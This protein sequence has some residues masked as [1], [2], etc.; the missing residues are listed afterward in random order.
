MVSCDFDASGYRLPTEAEWEY[1]ARAG[2]NYRY[3]GADDIIHV[4]WE[5]EFSQGRSRAV[6]QKKPNDF[7]LYD[8]SGNVWEWCWDRFEIQYTADVDPT[9]GEIGD[10]RVLRGGSW[11]DTKEKAQVGY[12]HKVRSSDRFY[13]QGFRLARTI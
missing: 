4:G 3:A 8:I 2:T 7:G 6:G 10:Y 1:A 11:F 13:N 9:G 12:R 5:Q